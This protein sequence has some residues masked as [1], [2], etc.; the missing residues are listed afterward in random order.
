MKLSQEGARKGPVARYSDAHIFTALSIIHREG[1]ISRGDLA[2]ELGLGEGSTRNILNTM[3]GWKQIVIQRKGVSLTPLGR[4]TVESIPLRF[5][6]ISNPKYVKGDCQ[7]G[8]LVKGAADRIN[9]GMAQRDTG[10]RLGSDGAS[11]FVMRDGKII[12]PNDYNVDSEDPEFA[13]KIRS[14]GIEEGDALIIAGSD[15]STVSTIAA[16][17]I[18][19]ALI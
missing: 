8:I 18:G 17:G 4:E 6:N 14:V 9:D 1:V 19:L 15:D 7:Q 5:V 16:A 12:F 3:E 13:A 10:I 11:V 2:E